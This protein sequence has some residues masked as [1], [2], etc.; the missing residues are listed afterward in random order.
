MIAKLTGRLDEAGRDYA[1][2]D[3]GGVGYR[4]RCSARTLAALPAAGGAVSVTTEMH[5]REDAIE[6]FGFAEMAERDWFRLLTTV[7]GVG[8]RIALA[9]LSALPAGE[10]ARAI[11]TGDRAMLT[12]ADGV[13]P[14]LAT[15]IATE[16]KDKVASLA[17]VPAAADGAAG[18]AIVASGGAAADAASALV[19]LGYRRAEAEAAIARAAA[20]VGDGASV[21]AMIAQAL[22]ELAR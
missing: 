12:R 16:L 6:L 3:V 9:I 10:L 15:R 13:G 5:V 8:A 17:A 11:A 21:E 1:V 7:Q 14:K 20:K 19:N 18:A 2:I 4:V 22:R